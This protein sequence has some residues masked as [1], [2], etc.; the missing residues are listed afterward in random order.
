MK[1]MLDHIRCSRVPTDETRDP[2]LAYIEGRRDI[3]VLY[4]TYLLVW[5]RRKEDKDNKIKT[6]V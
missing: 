1:A 3:V 6:L 2:I 5:S 4:S